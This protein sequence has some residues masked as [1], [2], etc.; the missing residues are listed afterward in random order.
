MAIDSTR[1]LCLNVYMEAIWSFVGDHIFTHQRHHHHLQIEPHSF[2]LVGLA[3]RFRDGTVCPRG[4]NC[5]YCSGRNLAG[6]SFF[7]SDHARFASTRMRQHNPLGT[8]R[9][10]SLPS[11]MHALFCCVGVGHVDR[12][13]PG[14]TPRMVD[15][16]S[17]NE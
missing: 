1:L 6:R 12:A 13:L 8:S 15:T 11:V 3:S 4:R 16:G 7:E 17:A 5:R 10:Y 2:R 14:Y 9:V